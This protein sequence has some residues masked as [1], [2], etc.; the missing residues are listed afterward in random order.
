MQ[1]TD[2]DRAM[3]AGRSGEAV[4]TAMELLIAVAESE[5]A[6]A[7]L[8]ISAAHIDGGLYHGEAGLDFARDLVEGGG[9]VVVPT[10]M[11]VSSLDLLHPDLYRGDP[12]RATTDEGDVK[13][14]LFERG[15]GGS[16]P[17]LPLGARRHTG[18]CALAASR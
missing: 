8:D 17:R 14:N 5:E 10:T 15:P 9:R 11:N 2:K 13:G 4:R 1:L 12:G 7:L 6:P 3:L 18:C 16:A